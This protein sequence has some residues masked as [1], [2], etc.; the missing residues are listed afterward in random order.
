MKP[1]RAIRGFT[2]LEIMIV[3]AVMG[4]ILLIGIPAI[5]SALHREALTQA[6][7]DLT[8]ACTKARA[9]A[10][11]QGRTAEL[12]IFPKTGKLEIADAISYRRVEESSPEPDP[13]TRTGPSY[14]VQLSD[15]IT[16]ELL[17]INFYEFKDADVARVHFFPN[18][19]SDEFTIVVRSDSG[20]RRKISL[21]VVTALTEVETF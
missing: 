11:L 18:G 17:D 20:E 6:I 7:Y 12:R 13:D 4:I 1:R 16:I 2:L 19:T 15:Q 3:V 21:E 14:S 8:G 9:R 5:R 10:I